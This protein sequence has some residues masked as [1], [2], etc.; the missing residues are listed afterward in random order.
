MIEASQT[1][2]IQRD[3]RFWQSAY[4]THGPAVMG[5]LLRR[6]GRREEAE[7]LLQET[8]VRAIRVDSFDGDNLRGY[9]L[10]IARNLMIN[11]LRRPLRVV[12]VQTAP[13]EQPFEDVAAAGD[14]P[15]R[16]A[17][18]AAFQKRLDRALAG[19]NE[20]HRRAFELAVF[21]QHSYAEI[22]R[23]TG[24]GLPR[25]KSN[26]HRARKRL[27]ARLGKYLPADRGTL[28]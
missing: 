19:L 22:S 14:T 13:E 18:W 25:V 2:S 17:E 9:L 23:L 20:D 27:I 7:D 1:V 12:P 24:W 28:S 4:R 5:F 8:F 16:E 6:L 26:I 11:R 15:E 21:E 10:C 3:E